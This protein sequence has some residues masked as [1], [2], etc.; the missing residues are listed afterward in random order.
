M[1][2]MKTTEAIFEHGKRVAAWC[3]I[4]AIGILSLLPAAE[5]GPLRT[6]LGGHVEHLATYAATSVIT[7]FAYLDHSRFKIAASFVLYG[8]ILEF[9]Q[10]FVPG[11]SSSFKDLA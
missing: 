6:S 3:C 9:L 11:R 1:E 4:G 10:R 2:S 5:V 7:A 8:A